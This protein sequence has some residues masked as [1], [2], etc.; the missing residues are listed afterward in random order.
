[1]K[2][3]PFR[4]LTY[5]L[6][7]GTFEDV[8]F[9]Q[10]G[11]VSSIGLMNKG[12]DYHP[13]FHQQPGCPAVDQVGVWAELLVMYLNIHHHHGGAGWLREILLMFLHSTFECC[14]L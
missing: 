2:E 12:L 7:K 13:K 4:E 14:V 11:Y 8:Y 9:L 10:V 6:F 3:L 5:P 1:M